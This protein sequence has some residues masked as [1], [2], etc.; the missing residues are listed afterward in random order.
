[1][2]I[3][4]MAKVI[5]VQN[6]KGGAGKTTT[7]TNLA[8]CMAVGH[9]LRVLL[10]DHDPQSSSSKWAARRARPEDD[11]ADPGVIPVISMGKT[12]SRDLP[13][14]SSSYD[15]VIID[16]L[17]QTDVLTAAA[18]KVAD[19]VIVPIQ[20]SPYDLWACEA[21][22]NVIKE[23]QELSGGQPKA[24]LLVSQA[25]P[26]TLLER[27]IREQLESTGFYVFEAQTIRR[28]AY[29]QGVAQGLSVMDL[30]ATDKARIEFEAITLEVLELLK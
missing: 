11:V 2:E 12:L 1:M 9:G 15:I 13:A 4:A 8:S 21:T 6:E 5:A 25:R 20:P 24:A 17:P 26:N 30:P 28:E 19:L 7:S 3:G 18:V 23:R 22:L 14:L 10:V 16:G 27:G 29:A